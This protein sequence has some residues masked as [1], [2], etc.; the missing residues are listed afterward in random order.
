MRMEFVR[1]FAQYFVPFAQWKKKILWH[2]MLLRLLKSERLESILTTIKL[3]LYLTERNDVPQSY[4]ISKVTK[5]LFSYISLFCFN[6]SHVSFCS[7]ALHFVSY[8]MKNCVSGQVKSG[9]SQLHSHYV[10]TCMYI[11]FVFWE[12]P[13]SPIH[14]GCFTPFL[15]MGF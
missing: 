5:N 14:L 11:K 2:L 1:K 10:C 12:I 15:L 6:S 4:Y 9:I 3:S 13:W 7:F 8:T